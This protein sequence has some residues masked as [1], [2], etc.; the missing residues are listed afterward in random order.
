MRL[1]TGLFVTLGF[2]VVAPR[3]TAQGNDKGRQSEVG[4][5]EQD[6]QSHRNDGK[7]TVTV[8]EPVTSGFAKENSTSATNP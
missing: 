2:V 5:A 6:V 1:I 4:I 3:L 7:T 8:S